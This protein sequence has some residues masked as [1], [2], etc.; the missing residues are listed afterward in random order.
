M[1]RRKFLALAGIGGAV[2]ALASGKFFT[3]TFEYSAENLIKKELHFL[4]LDDQGVK[5]FVKEY[6]KV[7]DRSYKL[8][9]RGYSLLGIKASQSGKIHQLVSSYLLSSDFFINKLD[10]TR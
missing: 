4:A 1:K 3:T 10:E 2:A 5:N 7:R 8:S 6:S 9:I